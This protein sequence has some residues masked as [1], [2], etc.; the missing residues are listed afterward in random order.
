M[1][2]GVPRSSQAKDHPVIPTGEFHTEDNEIEQNTPRVMK[3]TGPAEDSLDANLV[4]PANPF[5]MSKEKLDTLAFMNELVTIRIGTTTDKNAAQIF[6]TDVN[7]N[8]T[9][10]RR[11]ETKTVKRFIVDH[12]L[13]LKETVYTQQEIINAEGIRQFVHIP[14]TALKYDFA[15]V[16]DDNPMGKSWERGVLAEP[17]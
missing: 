16:R 11:G 17:G 14:H 4:I 2:K 7:N 1:P 6:E 8:P 5:N 3:S 9:M 13:R 10:F 15:I 12:L